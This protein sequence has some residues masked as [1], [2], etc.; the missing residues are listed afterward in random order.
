MTHLED[1]Q[2]AI[3]VP[4]ITPNGFAKLVRVEGYGNQGEKRIDQGEN[5]EQQ[6]SSANLQ[7]DA[8]LNG[9]GSPVS[10]DLREV[11]KRLV[12]DEP[13]LELLEDMISGFN[14]F[15]AMGM[16]DQELRHSDFLR[17]LLD[18]GESHSIGDLFARRFLQA[19]LGVAEESGR[20][21]PLSAVELDVMDLGGAE[22]YRE[23]R[24]IDV[25]FAD[26]A[27]KLVVA[28]ENKVWSGEGKDQLPAYLKAV[29]EDYPGWRALFL[30]LSPFGLEPSSPKYVSV[31]YEVV[32][33]VVDKIWAS[34]G[35]ALDPALR[36]ALEHYSQ[37]LGRHILGD[38]ELEEL[39]KRIYRKHR[40]ALD[41]IYEHRPDLQDEIRRLLEGLVTEQQ[42]LVLDEPSKHIKFTVKDWDTEAMLFGTDWTGS[43]RIMLFQ[44]ENRPDYLQLKLVLGPGDSEVRR[45][46]HEMAASGGKP[47]KAQKLGAK[48][49]TLY[50]RSWLSKK[51]LVEREF[52]DLE[53]RIQDRWQRFVDADLPRIKAA[54][55]SEEW[56]WEPETG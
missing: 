43:C 14:V 16:V 34:R 13:D 54:L 42:D 52:E 30:Y 55:D 19:A 49:N 3:S 10:G 17:F 45:R 9:P 8:Q 12:V 33:D 21:S 7:G 1:V 47:L 53:T 56:F 27:N 22:V 44:F 31:G 25:L 23:R 50:S 39:C 41:L 11:L 26:E 5:V 24:K 51:D 37:I 35:G 29:E 40:R 4:E 36:Y 28:V 38:T 48:W 20:E 6:N 32:R 2:V 18:P 15:E 46:L